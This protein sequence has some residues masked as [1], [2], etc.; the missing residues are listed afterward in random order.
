MYQKKIYFK[1]HFIQMIY[2]KKDVIVFKY[3]F[4]ININ[5]SK[6]QNKIN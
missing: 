6:K 5:F 1:K 4:V 3:L 2:Y